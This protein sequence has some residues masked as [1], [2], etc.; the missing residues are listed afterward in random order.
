M[1]FI[2]E[3]PIIGNFTVTMI[4]FVFVIGI[5]VFV[6]EYG[7]YIVGRWRGIH[8]ETFSLGFGPVIYARTDKRGTRW[9][10]AVIPLGGYVKFLG[11]RNAASFADDDA[12][13]AMNAYDRRRSFPAASVLSRSLT[14]VA[15]PVANFIL[16]I[17][18]FT[19]LILWQG[20]AIEHPTFGEIAN[21]PT[22]IGVQNGDKIIELN[23]VKV[24]EQ[25]GGEL[26]KYL[27]LGGE[28]YFF[29]AETF[30]EPTLELF[31]ER[32]DL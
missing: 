4:A 9:Q 10:L 15:G 11:D 30:E 26:L 3:I 21:L 23:G 24:I 5:V 22:E 25:R 7:H 19:G 28:C 14:V 29:G 20:I 1:N 16:S 31:L 2:S 27:P 17:V 12:V 6:H 32:F 8:A 13:G 18:L